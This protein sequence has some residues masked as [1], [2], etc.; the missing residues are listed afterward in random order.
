[1]PELSIQDDFMVTIQGQP[2]PPHTVAVNKHDR[3]VLDV[4]IETAWEEMGLKSGWANEVE[5]KAYFSLEKK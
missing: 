4:D 3:H 1:L 2:I 5:V